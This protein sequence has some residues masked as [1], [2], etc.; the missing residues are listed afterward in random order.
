M[1]NFHEA[2]NGRHAQHFNGRHGFVGHL[3]QGRYK[4]YVIK[5]D[6]HLGNAITYLIHNPVRAGLC[7]SPADWRWT[8]SVYGD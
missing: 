6:E 7:G 4:A 1:N 2:C 3:F 8:M 5:D